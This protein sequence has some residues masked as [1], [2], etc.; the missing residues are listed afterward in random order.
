MVV[1]GLVVSVPVGAGASEE[2]QVLL[3]PPGVSVVV[4]H[5]VFVS[6]IGAGPGG[7]G[8]GGPGGPGGAGAGGVTVVV[9]HGGRHD[10]VSV[11]QST[12]VTITG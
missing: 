6:V 3:S 7:G 8:E 5:G 12:S 9:V 10:E 2:V 4:V 11:T 1:A